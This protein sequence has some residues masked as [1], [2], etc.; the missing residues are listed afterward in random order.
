MTDP[1]RS[2]RGLGVVGWLWRPVLVLLVAGALGWW[3]LGR[4]VSHSTRSRPAPEADPA[5]ADVPP[6]PRVPPHRSW[7]SQDV[8]EPAPGCAPQAARRCVEGDAWWV[9]GCGVTYAKADECDAAGCVGG[10]CGPPPP[11]GCGGVPVLGE[12]DGDLARGCE[13]GYPFEVDCAALG[14]RCV[15]TEGGPLCRPPSADACDPGLQPP[16]CDGEELW[17]CVEGE[18]QRLDCRAQGAICGRPPGGGAAACLR[19]HP[20]VRDDACDDACGCPPPDTEE[21]CDGLDNDGDGWIDESGSCP[22][23]D[24][25]VFVVVDEHGEGSFARDDIDREVARLQRGFARDD[26]FGLELRLAEVVELRQPQWLELDGAALDQLVNSGA[27]AGRR[28]EFYVP[29]VLTE[30]VLVDGVPRPGLSTVPNGVCGG[31]R[32]VAGR[33]PPLGVLALAKRRWDTTGAH[34]LGHFFGLCHTHADHPQLVRPLDPGDPERDG[35]ERACVDDCAIEGDGICDTP[36]DP[37]PAHCDPDPACAIACDDGSGPDPTNLMAYY[38]P[39]RVGFTAQQ[40]QLMRRSIALRRGWYPCSRGE[41]CPCEIVESACPEGMSC[42]R[43][44]GDEGPVLRCALDG[45][46]VPGGVCLDGLECSLGSQCIGQPDADSRCV[47]PCTDDTPGCNCAEVGGV[48]HPI[49]V[50]DLGR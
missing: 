22:P 6:P 46:A 43:F 33:Q 3:M 31:Q 42:R 39:C 40:A 29:I 28:E 13:G 4:P 34:E 17:A 12:C 45:P 35:D 5:P 27:V 30:R 10:E 49:C 50:D 7:R 47:R 41:G 24:L 38:P 11:P 48:S 37:G 9:D 18:G 1:P 23:V 32:R 21:V 8:V 25:V 14:R 15:A 26:E 19:L 36:I 44:V 2:R 16:R 20:P